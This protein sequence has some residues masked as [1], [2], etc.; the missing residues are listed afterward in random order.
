MGVG[1]KRV[2]G[3]MESVEWIKIKYIHSGD[4]LRNPFE[5]KLKY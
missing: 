4:T 5:H 3:V 1:D 2:R